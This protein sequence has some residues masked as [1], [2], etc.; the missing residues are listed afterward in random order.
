[1]WIFQKLLGDQ[2]ET[3]KAIT[4]FQDPFKKGK[5]AKIHM[6]IYNHEIMFST[7]PKISFGATVTFKS[8]N[9]TGEQEIKA[10]SF[11]ALVEK[12]NGF[13]NSMG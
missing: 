13:V 10:D 7:G 6:H 4:E 3:N 11:V 5:V 1:M 9:T 8:G 12:I 2:P